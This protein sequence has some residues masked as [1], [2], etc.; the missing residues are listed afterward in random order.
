M[1]KKVKRIRLGP[2]I[3]RP[4]MKRV[5]ERDGWGLP[6]VR[7]TRESPSP[8]Q[9]QAKPAGKRRSRKPLYPVRILLHGSTW[10]ALFQ[11]DDN[12]SSQQSTYK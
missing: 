2:R 7:V 1:L 8:S 4:P 12:G 6:E 11:I 9:N 10:T 3:Y 5:P